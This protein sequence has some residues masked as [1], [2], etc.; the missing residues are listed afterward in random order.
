[1]R[2]GKAYWILRSLDFSPP[3]VRVNRGRFDSFLADLVGDADMALAWNWKGL[4]LAALSCSFLT[5]AE[6]PRQVAQQA[7]ATEIR[8]QPGPQTLALQSKADVLIYGGQAGG[9]KTWFLTA[10]PLRRIHN[11]GFRAVIFRRTYPQIMGQGGLWEEANA[12]YRP[13]G[14]KMREGDKLDATFPSGATIA[15]CHLQHEKTKYEY[16]GHQICYL[17]FD[18]LTHFTESQFFYLLSRN[19]SA[20][21]I[22]P[23]VR[24][25][26]NKQ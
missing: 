25:T 9:G 24:A 3:F 12:L 18:E 11:G 23:Y 5:M 1:M 7:P 21:G 22:R 16:Q 10:E 17:G 14:G 15:F 8:A 4:L 13:Q 6:R 20:C 26:C 2:G 19:R